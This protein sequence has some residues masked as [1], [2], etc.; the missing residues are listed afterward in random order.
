[1]AYTEAGKRATMKYVKENYDRLNIKVPKGRRAT[2]E[3]VAKSQG[4]SINGLVNRFFREAAGLSESEWKAS[5]EEV[6]AE[7]E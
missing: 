3:A 1:M 2:V 4:E 7:D 6:G 5:P